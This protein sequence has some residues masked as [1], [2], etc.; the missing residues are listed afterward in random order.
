VRRVT[1]TRYVTPLREGGSLP[2]I[3]EGDDAG[4]YVAKFRG[5]GQGTRVLVAEVICGVLAEALGLNVPERVG[6][7][8]TAELGRNEPMTE[9]RELLN[10]SVGLN[11]G[12]DYLPGSITFDPVAGPPPDVE[13]ASRVVWLDALTMNV[14]RTPK[15]PNLLSW[16]QKLHLIDHGAA[17]YF[18]HAD[19]PKPETAAKSAFEPV[20]KHV[21]LPWATQLEAADA[22][23]R[24]ALTPAVIAR[25]LDEVPAEWLE[26][27]R[28]LY[29]T[30]FSARLGA[31]KPFLEEA[32]RARAGLV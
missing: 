21:L 10:R 28:A 24:A 7:E 3:V 6:V 13:T 8:V 16:H 14:D 9:I 32:L 19:P 2:A 15:N 17:L 25:A 5:A 23:G 30:F 29:E 11:V 4:L 1:A 27:R 31:T 26:G 20:G 18:H 22:H 12:L